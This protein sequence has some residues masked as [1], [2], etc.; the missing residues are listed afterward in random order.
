MTDHRIGLTRYDLANL[1]DGDIQTVI[2][3]LSTHFQ[4]EALKHSAN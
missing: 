4:A 3:A 1:I 2:D